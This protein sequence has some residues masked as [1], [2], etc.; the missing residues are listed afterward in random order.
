MI[1]GCIFDLDGVIV[2]TAVYHFKAWKRLANSLGFDFT[3]EDNEQLKGVNRVDSLNL[4]LKWGGVTKDEATKLELATRKNNWY[5]EAIDKMTVD[6]ILP[7]VLPLL[8]SLKEKGIR[9]A[10]GSASKNA[11]RVLK[12]TGIIDYFEVIMD[13]T[14]VTKGKPD[15]EVFLKGALNLGLEPKE[16]IVFEDAARGVEAALNGG[17][18]A[19]GIGEKSSLGA[20]HLVI[21]GFADIGFDEI[22]QE[23]N[24]TSINNFE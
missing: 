1:K 16:C 22:I 3:E 7:G 13:G 12:G 2:D 6:E 23:L 9:I 24:L 11:V 21:P 20:A 19:V 5:V 8:A 10:L 14:N 4:I 17:F 15:P 18:Y